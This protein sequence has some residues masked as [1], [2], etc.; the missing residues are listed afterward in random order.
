MAERHGGAPRIRA[1]GMTAVYDT[2]GDGVGVTCTH[3]WSVPRNGMP[4]MRNYLAERRAA[5]SAR[6]AGVAA[7]VAAAR[8]EAVK[9]AR[10]RLGPGPLVRRGHGYWEPVS[11]EE[12]E[13]P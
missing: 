4:E 9:R 8:A 7:L 2:Y 6:E 3:K 11:D 1:T 10:E 13:Q 12:G 5:D